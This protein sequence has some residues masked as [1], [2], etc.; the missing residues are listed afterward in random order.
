MAK[1]SRSLPLVASITAT[2]FVVTTLASRASA[3]PVAS[4]KSESHGESHTRTGLVVAGA[5]TFGISYGLA[6]LVA[7]T[8]PSRA[9]PAS[10]G[11]DDIN[12]DVGPKK[13][14][15]IPFAGPFMQ[16]NPRLDP[17]MNAVIASDGV[18][19]VAG[20]AMFIVGLAWRTTELTPDHASVQVSPVRMGRGGTGVALGGTF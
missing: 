17:A 5:V 3:D 10:G 19:Q 18:A 2:A 16:W 14:L 4:A 6:A 13:T 20:V 9:S 12:I 11:S 1:T 8:T 15:F 7:A